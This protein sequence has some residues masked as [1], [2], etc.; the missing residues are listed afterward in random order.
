MRKVILEQGKLKMY[1]SIEDDI[2]SIYPFM[3]QADKIECE[4]MGFTPKDALEVALG[5]DAVTYTVFDSYGVPFCMLGC[6]PMPDGTGY[7]WMLGTDSV[8]DNKFDFIKG[9]RFVVN[10]LTQPYGSVK[11]YV[12]K[13]NKVAI[14][15]LKWCGAEMGRELVFSDHPFYEFTITHK[16]KI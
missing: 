9:S 13:D 2:E 15:W 14:A 7:I 12:H 5:A 16:E 1:E 3:R 6:G 4:C 11:N 10:A 8:F